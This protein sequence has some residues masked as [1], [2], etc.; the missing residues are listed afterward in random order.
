MNLVSFL[1][2]AFEKTPTWVWVL[3]AYLIHIG[4]K[5]MVPQKV[6]LP[7]F[8]IMPIV[9]TIMKYKEFL[10]GGDTLLLLYILGITITSFIGYQLTKKDKVQIFK[11]ELAVKVPANP[12][13]LIITLSFF[14][15]KYYFGYCYARYP[16]T[17]SLLLTIDMI[18]SGLFSGYFLGKAICYTNTY[19]KTANFSS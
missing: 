17:T 14:I 18:V 16:D 10:K 13:M 15:L 19:C 2:I 7:R 1:T 3:L 8:F 4:I 11:D 9:L 6:Y 5:S 12:Y